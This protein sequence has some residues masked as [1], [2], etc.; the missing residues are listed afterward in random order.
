MLPHKVEPLLSVLVMGFLLGM[1]HATDADH[2]AAVATLA[3]AERSL[4]RTVRLGLAWGTGHTLVLLVVGGAAVLLGGE[5]LPPRLSQYLEVAV[6]GMLVLLGANVLRRLVRQRLH[7]HAHRHG[8]GVVH[9]HV[10][11]H[12][13]EGAHAL[14]AHDHAHAAA[15]PRQAL[16]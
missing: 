6:G 7:L 4:A 3:T 15:L 11:S 2:L 9:L 5:F 16:L 10:H 14:S 1:K 8:D 13:G 12:A